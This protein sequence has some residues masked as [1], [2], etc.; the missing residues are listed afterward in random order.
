MILG[1]HSEVRV[2][3]LFISPASIEVIPHLRDKPGEALV[4]QNHSAVLQIQE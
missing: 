3:I 4:M 1:L 2:E